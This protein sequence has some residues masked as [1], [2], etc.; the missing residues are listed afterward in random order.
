MM[1]SEFQVPQIL[2]LYLTL[3]PVYVTSQPF[4]AC[5]IGCGVKSS[6]TVDR[7][8]ETMPAETKPKKFFSLLTSSS[9]SSSVVTLPASSLDGHFGSA[10]SI[11]GQI[12][13][14][15]VFHDSLQPQQVSALSALGECYLFQI[16]FPGHVK[17][18]LFS[19]QWMA[20]IVASWRLQNLTFF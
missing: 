9:Q 20:I 13:S 10:E 11:G 15:C 14:V 2:S 8:P 18:R 3:I 4:T 16:S 17:K 6:A 1:N 19:V 12:G 5:R 7:G